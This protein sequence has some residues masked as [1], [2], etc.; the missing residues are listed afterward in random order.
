MHETE[1]SSC[2]RTAH[3]SVHMTVHNCVTQHST[4]QFWQYS[5]LSYRQSSWLKCCL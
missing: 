4:E 2:V 1:N 3:I 5:L